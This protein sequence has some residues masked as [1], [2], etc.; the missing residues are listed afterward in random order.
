METIQEQ[1][2]DMLSDE[3]VVVAPVEPA[4]EPAH[5]AADPVPPVEPVAAVEV[6]PVEPVPVPVV[7]LDVTVEPTVQAPVVQPASSVVPEPAASPLQAMIDQQNN[8]IT[9][10]RMMIEK[11][12]T[13]ATSPT[14]TA[15][16]IEPT[17]LTALPFLEKEEDLDKAL[18]S[19]DNFNALLT[20][21]MEKAQ[22]RMLVNLPQVIGVM[23]EKIVTQRLAAKEFYDNNKDLSAN[24]AFVSIVANEMAAA[25]PE[26]DMGKLITHLGEEVRKRLV[27]VQGASPTVLT[28]GVVD[29]PT[30]AFVSPSGARPIGGAPQLDKMAKDILDMISD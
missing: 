16:Q 23:A 5:I 6:P 18:N 27:L 15:A 12:A 7:D 24:K 10:L 4:V 28:P 30:P 17:A 29:G 22:E 13:Q 3:P 21:V 9:E 8:T 19:K 11:L 26:W 2:N 20:T 14:P 1:V 25:N